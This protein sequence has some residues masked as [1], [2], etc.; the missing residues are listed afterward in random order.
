M[1][2]LTRR[3]YQKFHTSRQLSHKDTECVNILANGMEKLDLFPAFPWRRFATSSYP[4]DKIRACLPPSIRRHG[5]HICVRQIIYIFTFRGAAF[6]AP[7][8]NSREF[9]HNLLKSLFWE[10]ENGKKKEMGSALRQ[11][12][13]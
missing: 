7:I 6:G 5:V 13:M 11:M 8:L 9:I 3:G 12:F 2:V 4:P 1:C 10:R